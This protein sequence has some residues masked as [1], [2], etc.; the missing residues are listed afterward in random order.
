M[1]YKYLELKG[2]V[3]IL[4]IYIDAFNFNVIN[5]TISIHTTQ[6]K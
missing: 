6:Y 4:L 3:C 5:K 1:A 2:H